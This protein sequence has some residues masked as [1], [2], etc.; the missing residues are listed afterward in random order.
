MVS[1]SKTSTTNPNVSSGIGVMV[2]VGAGVRESSGITL[3]FTG[4]ASGLGWAVGSSNA[5]RGWAAGELTPQPVKGKR[6][7]S[8][9]DTLPKPS[10]IFFITD[11]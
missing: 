10:E 2:A 11:S 8:S 1:P 5:G 7:N 9:K 4:E 6:S 3:V